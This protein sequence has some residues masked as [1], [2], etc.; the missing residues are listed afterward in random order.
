MFEQHTRD[1]LKQLE[2]VTHRGYNAHQVFD[3]W[4]GLMFYAL[5]RNDEEYLKIVRRYRNE[6]PK[7]EREID[8][9]CNAFGLL[10]K[11]MSETNQE[12]LGEIYMQWEVANKYTGQF[13]TPWHVAEFMARILNQKGGESIYEPACGSGVMLIAACKTMTNEQLDKAVFVGQDID[14][15]CV[16]MCALNLTF[17]NLN[18]YAI[19]G[20]TLA[21]ERQRIFRTVRSYLGGSLVVIPAEQ[22]KPVVEKISKKE[23][24]RIE[25]PERIIQPVLF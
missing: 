13:F 17:F 21:G 4:I 19:W 1:I 11:K 22:V 2:A 15:T 18:G 23:V 25:K 9:F 10:M 8:H 24:V 16:M 6:R 3:D 5:Q 12:L 7:G 20:N 14:F